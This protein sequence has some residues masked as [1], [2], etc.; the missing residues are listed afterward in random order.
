MS[1]LFFELLSEE[2]PA[3]MQTRAR[4]EL[5]R[6]VLKG[7]KEAGLEH[8]ESQ[9][10]VTPRRLVLSVTGLP[11]KQPD[12]SEEKKGP[13]VGAPEQA[14]AGFMKANG[15]Q[16][17]EEAE[18]RETPKGNF[19]F[20]VRE[21]AGRPT[22]DVLVEVLQAALTALAWP[23]SMR[24]GQHRVRWVRPMHSIIALFDG[25]PLEGE[26][27]LGED[28]SSD[29]ATIAFGNSTIGHRFIAP[30]TI[31]V[32]GLTDYLQ[33]LRDAYVIVDQDER[34]KMVLSQARALAKDAGLVLK[35]DQGLL[36]EVAGL[37][38]WPEALMGSI[39]D[40][41][42]EVP[43]EVLITSMRSHQKYFSLLTAE[44]GMADRF[45][46]VSNM[47]VAGED[48]R[49]RNIVSGN[50]RVLSARLSDA[51]FFWDLDRE[52]DLRSR[53]AMLG[54]IV[55]HAKLGTVKDKVER[56]TSLAVH[57]AGLIE[58]A[59]MLDVGTSAQLAKADLVTGMV[60]EFPELQGIMGRYYALNDGYPEVVANAIA[61]HYG[62]LGPNDRCP[63]DPTAICVALADKLDTLVGFWAI[64]EK[65]TGSKDP[66]AL[67][68]AALG[69]IRLI[70]ENK[71]RFDLKA[72]IKVSAKTYR[73]FDA[74]PVKFP[75]LNFLAE[76]LKVAL[77]DKGVRHDHIQ[78]VYNL[79]GENDV[80]RMLARVEVLSDFLDSDDGANL[81]VAYKRAANISRIESKKDDA[82]YDG[83][84]KAELLVEAEEKALF[85]ALNSAAEA[86]EPCLEA[87]D[88]QQAI[89]ILAALRQPVDAFFDKV[90]VNAD[91]PDLRLNRLQLLSRITGTMGRIADFTV[92]EG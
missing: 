72:L 13:K 4:D 3:R 29:S 55:F 88:F 58:G 27:H 59:E 68:R 86:L 69:V 40:Q 91:E 77:R 54:D 67:R 16:T 35:E 51:K 14:L 47:P 30:Q 31:E 5:Q 52:E 90:T 26:I 1:E 12:V 84:V 8:G 41:F 37:V 19:Y 87:E 49:K 24:W 7:L 57:I 22:A 33:K 82:S 85:A 66:F 83:N 56:V 44:G 28:G 89:T 46:V 20:A 75:V 23:K 45:I 61:D 2:I 62:P 80:V 36:E 32:T 42:M 17:I 74:K 11:A 71:L 38:E 78:A 10:Y 18:V 65:P 63:S 21:I 81:L 60:G 43:K 79:P 15:L 48:S 34:Q 50:E 76:R 25:Q 64:D 92:I 73:T 70:V 6:L 53:V 9:A 39:D